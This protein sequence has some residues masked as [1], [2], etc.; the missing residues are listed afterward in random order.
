VNSVRSNNLSLKYL[1]FTPSGCKDIG[2]RKF[3]TVAKTQFLWNKNIQKWK[4]LSKEWR[5]DI[6]F[7]NK[8]IIIKMCI[9]YIMNKWKFYGKL[10]LKKCPDMNVVLLNYSNG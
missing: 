6:I 8:M 3:E 2:F 1:W 4:I 10:I 9:K 5:M 7:N